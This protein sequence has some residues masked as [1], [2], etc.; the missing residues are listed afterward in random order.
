[1]DAPICQGCVEREARIADLERRVAEQDLRIRQLEDLVRKLLGQL[2][3]APE[4]TARVMEDLPKPEAKKPSGRKAGGQ[5]NHPPHLKKLL[6]LERVTNIVM[7]VPKYC[8]CCQA[9]L[10]A[11]AAA[12][13]PEPSR[14]QIAELPTLRAEITEHQGHYRTCPRCHHVT[15]AAIPAEV[16]AESVGAKLTGMMSYLVGV[17]HVSKRGV[18]EI[19]EEVFEVPISL[20]KVAALEQEMSEALQPA[21]KEAV[22]EVRAAAS[23]YVDE[24]G[25]KKAGRKRWLWA[26]ATKL[27]VVFLIHARRNLIALKTLLGETIVGFIH[28]DRWKT[29]NDIPTSQRQL[30][31]A[32]LK[33]NFEKWLKRG[34]KGKAV[35]E[36]FLAIHHEVF[37]VWHLFRGGSCDREELVKHM[38]PLVLSLRQLLVMMITSGEE[39]LARLGRNLLKLEPALWTFVVEEGVEP[40]NN[41][42]ERVQRLAVLWR[43]CCFGCHSESGCRFVE[44]LLTVVQT[45][46]LQKRS[47]LDF[48]TKAIQAHRTGGSSPKLVANG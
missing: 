4:A 21:H 32:H 42:G 47:V 39:K 2:P 34:E 13:D 33:R 1:M 25:W 35:A 48:L 6:P 5:P 31:W 8:E 46:R 36:A 7:H 18:E 44:R 40:T 41:H 37:K 24:T 16:R 9:S 26:A 15:Q 11:K 43:K 12:D 45:L 10:P 3:P 30:C 28:S 14:H 17:H 29:Y 20:G 23:K 19:V 38:V 27:V 22:A